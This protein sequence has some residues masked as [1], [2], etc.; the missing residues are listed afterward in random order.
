MFNKNRKLKLL[1]FLIFLATGTQ[2]LLAAKIEGFVVGPDDKPIPNLHVSVNQTKLADVTDS[3]GYFF[4]EKV[5]PG[6]YV[7]KF[8]HIGFKTKQIEVNCVDANQIINLDR[9]VLEQKIINLNEVVVTATRSDRCIYEV[10]QPINLVSKK[11]IKQRSAKTSAEALREETG[12]FVQKTNHGGGSAILR[13]LS[14]NQILILVDGIRLNNST[15]RLGN[16]QYLT[17]VDNNSLQQIEVV[18]GPASV[19]YGSDA[20]GGTINLITKTPSFDKGNF[21]FNYNILG[22][23]ASADAEKMSSTRFSIYSPHVVMLA[24]FSYKNYGDLQRGRNSDYFSLENSTNGILQTPSGYHA[25]DFDTK[26]LFRLNSAQLVTL[27]YQLSRQQKVPRY[28]KYEINDYYRWL[29]HPQNRDL[30]YVNYDN[31]LSNP[32]ITCLKVSLSFQRQVEGR[33]IQKSITSS[34]EKTKADVRTL[35]LTVQCQSVWQKHNFTYGS[36]F[37]FDKVYSETFT[38]NTQTSET[39]KEQ[40]S[41]YPDGANYN[42]AGLFVQDEI[43]LTDRFK[44]TTG[45]RYSFVFTSYTIPYDSTAVL[46][47]GAVKQNFQ[48]ITGTV[49]A[50]YR[51]TDFFNTAVNVGQ[52][53]RAPNL[54]DFSKFGES[55]GETFE[56]P[57][58][59]LKPEKMINGDVGFRFYFDWLKASASV[60]YSQISDLVASANTLYN[61]SPVLEKNDVVYI[62]KTKRNIGSAFVRGMEATAELNVNNRLKIYGNITTTYGQNTSLNEPVGGIPPMF[63]LIG[64]RWETENYDASFY[65]RFAGKQD[66]LSSDDLDDPRIP[67]GGTPGW[68]TINFRTSFYMLSH[69]TLQLALENILDYN[70]REHGSGINGPG[71]NLIISLELNR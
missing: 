50:I 45:V 15:Y 12:V 9:I 36:E 54:S 68:Q 60:Y 10:P 1:F 38:I 55:K 64:L 22:R 63:G 5:L 24:G 3:D 7:I 23:Y 48:A 65:M 11:A 32:F 56:I 61:G 6:N 59:N 19:L 35:G 17:T 66:R 42:S 21:L 43:Y 13:G 70:Y 33:E 40:R 4:I 25:Y 16:H 30:I 44:L 49:G 2:H 62:V 69:L 71:R 58:P 26:F 39:N 46:D 8:D 18:R 14:S 27:A 52:A 67:A 29:Y 51:F 20:L 41:L 28:D 53:F 57:N 31:K 37:Y 47:L 34:S